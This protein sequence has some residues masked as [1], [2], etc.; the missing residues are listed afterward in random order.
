MIL[1]LLLFLWLLVI[2]VFVVV[3]VVDVGVVVFGRISEGLLSRYQA[4]LPHWSLSPK[5]PLPNYYR[6]FMRFNLN[7][8]SWIVASYE[9]TVTGEVGGLIWG[10]QG[11]LRG[12]RKE[13]EEPWQCQVAT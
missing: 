10:F 4:L 12:P 6:T 9:T 11:Q 1:L 3:F 5:A 2:V 7:E 13:L 8:F